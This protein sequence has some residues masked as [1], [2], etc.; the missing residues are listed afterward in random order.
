MNTIDHNTINH[1]GIV[2]STDKGKVSVRITQAAACATC[3][4]AGH[5]NA[6]EQQEKMIEIYTPDAQRYQAGEPVIVSTD[7]HTGHRAVWLG[8]GLPL[9][10][11][12]AT[13]FLVRLFSGSD[14]AAALSA[15]AILIPYYSVLYLFRARI[16]Q[17]VNFNISGKN[18]NTK[19]L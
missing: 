18:I 16:A 6:S 19:T 1:E 15:I 17:K 3:K 5:C 4:I 8:Y 11:M 10:L 13:L 2:T 9:V 12:I 7:A 14:G